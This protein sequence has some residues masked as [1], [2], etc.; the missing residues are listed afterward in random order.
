[1]LTVTD[2]NKTKRQRYS[3]FIDGEFYGVL[4]PDIYFTCKIKIG[5]KIQ[6]EEIDELI[7]RSQTVIAK[8]RALKLLSARA[9]T[10]KGLKDKLLRD[11]DSEAA[12][13]V[14]SRM[15][16]LGLI[17]DSD[18]ALRYAKD[19]INLR[20]FSHHRTAMALA[21]R[22][23]SREVTERTLEQL[24]EE[25]SEKLIYRQIKKKYLNKLEDEGD[26]RRTIGALQRRGFQYGDI[27]TVINHLKDD[28]DYY[29]DY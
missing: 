10:K 3:I 27:R 8:E 22:G 4:H 28:P 25:D 13:A 6:P 24:G 16:E 1:M 29:I 9:Y 18:Y 23:I 14:V 21:Q 12:D 7:Y 17:D 20:G 2:I 26:L 11:V 19:C 5:D 15:E